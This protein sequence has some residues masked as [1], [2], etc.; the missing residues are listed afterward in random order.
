[1]DGLYEA[2]AELRQVVRAIMERVRDLLLAAIDARDEAQRA[3]LSAALDALLHLDGEIRRHAEPRFLV[4]ATLVR[5]AV[6]GSGQPVPAPSAA[7][8][9]GAPGPP[10]VRVPSPP[11]AAPPSPAPVPAQVS[12]PPAAEAPASPEAETI[13]PA[14]PVPAAATAEPDGWRA[15]VESLHPLRRGYFKEARAE[16]QGTALVLWFPYAFH[17]QK[18]KEHLGEIEPLVKG[19]LGDSVTI[20]LRLQEAAPRPVAGGSGHETPSA[21]NGD[22]EPVRKAAPEEHPMVQDIVRKLEGRV[23]RVREIRP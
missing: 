6:D 18:A 21:G 11:V 3:R 10:P 4:E 5:L 2:G 7:A 15:L 16:V 23:T 20:E 1:V 14:A 19:W 22:G 8:A 13:A 17:H 12:R 9:V